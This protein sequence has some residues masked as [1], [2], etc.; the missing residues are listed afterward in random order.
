MFPY[1][2]YASCAHNCLIFYTTVAANPSCSPVCK[3]SGTMQSNFCPSHFGESLFSPSLPHSLSPSLFFSPAHTLSLTLL[4]LL[5]CNLYLS[6]TPLT[7]LD[8]LPRFF[9]LA[10]SGAT[11][12]SCHGH[13]LFLRLYGSNCSPTHRASLRTSCGQRNHRNKAQMYS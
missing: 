12:L 1:V 10:I 11:T 5:S 4:I 3:R 13:S 9:F 6:L 7:L 8:F 2:L